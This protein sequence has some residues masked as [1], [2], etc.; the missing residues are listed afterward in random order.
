MRKVTACKGQGGLPGGE[1]DHVSCG[2]PSPCPA[3]GPG[4]AQ[5]AGR[6]QSTPGRLAACLADPQM[7]ALEALSSGRRAPGRPEPPV[8]HECHASG[9]CA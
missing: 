1:V 2:F 5:P 7:L 8:P 3:E 6:L 4:G 9:N